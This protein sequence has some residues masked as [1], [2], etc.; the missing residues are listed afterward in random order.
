MFAVVRSSIIANEM[1]RKTTAERWDESNGK[2]KQPIC[3]RGTCVF[4]SSRELSG[5][6]Q[7]GQM[8]CFMHI[9]IPFDLKRF[10]APFGTTKHKPKYQQRKNRKTSGRKYSKRKPTI[11]YFR[12]AQNEFHFLFVWQSACYFPYGWK[13]AQN[14]PTILT[15]NE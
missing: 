14:N 1:I 13:R 15:I 9:N 6:F 12:F 3:C 8:L 10:S 4:D 7:T 11:K 2:E 5:T